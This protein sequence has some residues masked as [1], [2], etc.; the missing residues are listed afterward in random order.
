MYFIVKETRRERES[1]LAEAA[2]KSTQR[3]IRGVTRTTEEAYEIQRQHERE[4]EQFTKV[5]AVSADAPESKRANAET[6]LKH[7]INP[8]TMETLHSPSTRHD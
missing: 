5:Y 8:E 2:S 3:N 4:G 6:L 7:G 1:R